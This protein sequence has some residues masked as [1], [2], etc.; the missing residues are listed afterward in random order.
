MGMESHKF[1]FSLHKRVVANTE[2]V[3]YTLNRISQPINLAKL[4]LDLS[5]GVTESFSKILVHF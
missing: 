2:V 4:M 1:F 5:V 3:E